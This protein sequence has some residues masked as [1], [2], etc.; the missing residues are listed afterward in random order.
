MGKILTDRDKKDDEGLKESI[1]N[2]IVNV[3]TQQFDDSNFSTFE[4]NQFE[5]PGGLIVYDI[6]IDPVIIE[7]NPNHI[8]DDSNQDYFLT[9]LLHGKVSK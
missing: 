3:D 5:L 1:C 4:C 8:D 7:R 9:T 6:T 2:A